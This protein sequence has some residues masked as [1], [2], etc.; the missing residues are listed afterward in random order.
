MIPTLILLLLASATP[1]LFRVAVLQSDGDELPAQTCEQALV[2]GINYIDAIPAPSPPPFPL[3]V[4]AAPKI[5]PPKKLPIIVATEN[6]RIYPRGY[7][8][9]DLPLQPFEGNAEDISKIGSVMREAMAGKRTRISVF[10]ASHTEG[11]YWTGHIRRLLQ[12]RYGD[13]GH[14]F[15]MP[16]SMFSRTRANDINKCSTNTWLTD[17]VGKKEGHN[18]DLFG[19]GMTASSS[20]PLDFGWIETTHTNPFGR[21]VAFYDIF[22]LIQPT[23]GTLMAALD[24]QNPI[25]IPTNGPRTLFQHTRIETKEAP[26]RLTLSPAGDGTVRLF[27]MSAESSGPGVLVDAIGIRGREAKTWLKWNTSLF[28]QVYRA[29]Q[30]DIVVL[31][32]GTNEA[33]AIDYSMERYAKDLRKV[34]QKLR[35]VDPTVGCIL[36]GPSD[37]GKRVKRHKN[38]FKVWSRTA[39]VA[40]VQRTVAPEYGCVFWDWQQATGGEGSMIAW[41][42]TN[43]PLAAKDMIHFSAAGYVHSAQQFI[44]ALDNALENY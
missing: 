10:G 25:L 35:N 8:P 31:A 22:T 17:F 6:K 41:R 30:P 4:T 21:H 13:I 33:N 12:S 42:Y 7:M 29:L 43:P 38:K 39:M 19:I 3:P 20:D 5:K 11:D 16:A 40:D 44:A 27:G 1:T 26:H 15:I 28:Q 9:E 34:L 37:R 32:Y 14:G 18:D 24:R 36:V 2:E 23:G